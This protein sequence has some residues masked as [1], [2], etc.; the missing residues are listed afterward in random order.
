[1]YYSYD[2]AC[3]NKTGINT[4]IMYGVISKYVVLRKGEYNLQS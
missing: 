3:T 4:T 1:M 2:H